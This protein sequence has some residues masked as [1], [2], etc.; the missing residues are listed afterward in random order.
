[1]VLSGV[2]NTVEMRR[3]DIVSYSTVGFGVSSDAYALDHKPKMTIVAAPNVLSVV[4]V[5]NKVPRP[6][7]AYGYR[8]QHF[9]A[10]YGMSWMF[11]TASG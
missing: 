1:M 8:I 6:Q 2:G 9:N 7:R 3:G 10:N 4:T 11:S 5:V